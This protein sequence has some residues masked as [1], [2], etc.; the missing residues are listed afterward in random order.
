MLVHV[1]RQLCSSKKPGNKRHQKNC[2]ASSSETQLNQLPGSTSVSASWN[3]TLYTP[4]PFV[5]LQT[6]LQMPFTLYASLY[7]AYHVAQIQQRPVVGLPNAQGIGLAEQF[8]QSPPSPALTLAQSLGYCG[9][10]MKSVSSSVSIQ[11]ET[12]NAGIVSSYG[13][14]PVENVESKLLQKKNSYCEESVYST[15]GYSVPLSLDSVK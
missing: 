2:I 11:N 8:P 5:P 4:M 15:P 6:S 13:N 10:N 3:P 7:N 9:E 12:R 1:R 14:L